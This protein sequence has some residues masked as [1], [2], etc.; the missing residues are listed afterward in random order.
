MDDEGGRTPDANLCVHAE[1]ALA[2]AAENALAI[3]QTL[4]PTTGRYFL[5]GDDARPWCRCARCRDLSDGDQALLLAN[6]LLR[7]LRRVDHG[8]GLAHLA[9]HN[10]LWPPTRVKPEPGIFLEYAPIHRRYDR[11]YGT[12]RANGRMGEWESGGTGDPDELSVANAQPRPLPHPPI[13]PPDPL[14]ALDANLAVFG[15]EGAQALEYWL[16]VS[17]FSGWKR[18]AVRLP[19]NGDVFRAD[20]ATYA[21]RDVRHVT[22][23]AVYMDAEYVA[24]YGEPPL[25]EYGRA[26]VMRE[27]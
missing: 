20:L 25:E 24:R 1:G 2:I 8:A 17:R 27:A 26:L 10:T 16:D 3:R 19:W 23:F 12:E 21:A 4:R 11:A 15:A 9:Y 7:A 14:E 22:A 18:P 6:H 5:W 13:R